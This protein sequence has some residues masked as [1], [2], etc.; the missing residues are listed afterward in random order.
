MKKLFLFLM[1]LVLSFALLCACNKGSDTPDDGSSEDGGTID[2]ET[3]DDGSGNGDSP[4]DP[5]DYNKP[6][7][8]QTIFLEEVFLIS[9]NAAGNVLSIKHGKNHPTV[10]RET[11][12]F[13]YDAN[14]KVT[15]VA[16]TENGAEVK[17]VSF[18]VQPVEQEGWFA[19]H[20]EGDG[21]LFRC[22]DDGKIAELKVKQLGALDGMCFF[23]DT[24]GC[25]SSIWGDEEG[26]AKF[27]I[28][29]GEN[30]LSVA[31]VEKEKLDGVC[32][33]LLNEHGLPTSATFGESA[34]TIEEKHSWK[35]DEANRCVEHKIEDTHTLSVT[36]VR[37]EYQFDE[38]GILIGYKA[39]EVRCDAF[40]NIEYEH[41]SRYDAVGNAILTVS[42]D[43]MGGTACEPITTLLG[44]VGPLP[45]PTKEDYIFAGWYCDEDCEIPFDGYVTSTI[46][47]YACWKTGYKIDFDTLGGSIVPPIVQ[48][49]GTLVT[50]PAAPFSSFGVFEGWYADS[51]CTIPYTFS[52]MPAENITLFA[53]WKTEFKVTFK[54]IDRYGDELKD[55]DGSSSY[56]LNFVRY[57]T[58]ARENKS[59]NPKFFE[60][61]VIIGWNA[62]K[63]AAKAGTA[64]ASAVKSI[65][66][67][68]V[69]YSVIR[70]KEFK[71]V[72]FLKPDGSAIDTLDYLEGTAI[73][74]EAPRYV[75]AGQYLKRWKF[76]S[77]DEEGKQDSTTSCI[78]GDCTFKAIMGY[79]DGTIGLTQD[80]VMLDGKKD[81]A[82]TTSGAYLALNNQ[83]TPH[84]AYTVFEQYTDYAGIPAYGNY[85]DPTTVKADT[86]MV[87]DGA[88]IYLLIEVY[89]TT[90][91]CR[92]DAYVRKGIDSYFNDAIELWYCFEQD[93]S[94]TQNRTRVGL[95]SAGDNVEGMPRGGAKYAL[96]RSE[97]KGTVTGIGGGRSTHFDEIKYAVRNYIYDANAGKDLT[98]LDA[99]GVE[100]PSYTIELKIPA[101]TE[102]KADETKALYPNGEKLTGIDL[103]DFRA[104][105]RLYGRPAESNNINDYAFTDGEKLEVGDYVRFSLQVNDLKLSFEDLS[106]GEYYDCPRDLWELKETNEGTDLTQEEFDR[107]SIN[108]FELDPSTGKWI[109]ARTRARFT[110]AG[111][112]Q[113]NLD[114]YLCFSLGGEATG[115]Y[116]VAKF[117]KNPDDRRAQI[118]IG[119]DGQEYI[120]P[121]Q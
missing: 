65:K 5:I 112:T 41:E 43:S 23:F 26:E 6:V 30:S 31:L 1:V 24:Q 68:S 95:A 62:D 35:Y 44:N 79:T 27:N 117:Q 39:K 4:S 87:W 82:Y 46:T 7:D 85:A 21:V 73:G 71:K 106:S 103:E 8:K 64:D 17:K 67:D 29:Y 118:M 51:N 36:T 47:L 76:V 56:T 116:K 69:L 108:L 96:P 9:Q 88:Y 102:G 121:E 98:G 14:G 45:A 15:A 78:Y 3:P 53:K 60:K 54:Y 28:T 12:E 74:K 90:L 38:S 120:R 111:S 63:E 25:A 34:E 57:G 110:A 107:N 84:D 61:Y 113:Y 81:A 58:D 72:T 91:T 40:G 94:L 99:A 32:S 97:Y 22:T 20:Q 50:A 86:W 115:S 42:F 19:A 13:T 101:K 114:M 52:V 16:F 2:G 37:Y 93:A 104:T 100:A 109:N 10:Y 83:K 105:G 49:A 119:I 92:N 77:N 18:S 80:T 75:I 59:N 70:D 66:K 48:E 33:L 55:I 11:L 89:D